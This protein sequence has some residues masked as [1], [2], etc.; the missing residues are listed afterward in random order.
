MNFGGTIRLNRVGVCVIIG[1]CLLFVLYMNTNGIESQKTDARKN[2]E[3]VNLKKLLAA[4]ISV[5]VRGGKEV[6]LIKKGKDIGEKS[7]GNTK[8]GVNDP[9][10]QADYNSHCVMYYGLSR[11]FSG[12]KVGHLD[13]I[14]YHSL[15][16]NIS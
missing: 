1:A 7:K 12:L 16:N 8:E 9:V 13:K 2:I 3:T 14:N 4:A 11:S 10:T 5:A 15:T 6:V